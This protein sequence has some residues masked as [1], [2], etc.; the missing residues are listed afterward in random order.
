MADF[1]SYLRTGAGSGNITVEDIASLNA[2][3]SANALNARYLLAETQSKGA[4][5]LIPRFKPDRWIISCGRDENTN[6]FLT[7]S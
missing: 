2:V 1:P 4:P 5:G 3:E 7:L 6:H